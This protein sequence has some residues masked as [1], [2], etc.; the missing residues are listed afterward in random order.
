[1]K[2]FCRKRR[3]GCQHHRFDWTIVLDSRPIQWR[4]VRRKA[5]YSVARTLQPNRNVTGGLS[6]GMFKIFGREAM[7]PLAKNR[8][9][10]FLPTLDQHGIFSQHPSHQTN[11]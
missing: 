6:V 9:I 3:S 8:R 11:R 4:P 7:V 2:L 10:A 1:M 5:S